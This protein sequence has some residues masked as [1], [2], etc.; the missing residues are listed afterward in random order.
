MQKSTDLIQVITDERI[1]ENEA[2]GGGMNEGQM[3]E[4]EAVMRTTGG[5]DERPQN[6][7]E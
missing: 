4:S 5:G 2:C 7:N 3:S 1:G 6:G